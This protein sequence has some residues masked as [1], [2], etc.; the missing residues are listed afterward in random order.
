MQQT[1]YLS[2]EENNVVITTQTD[3]YSLPV[4]VGKLFLHDVPDECEWEQAIILIEDM[5]SSVQK[6]IPPQAELI[7]QDELLRPLAPQ[8]VLYRDHLERVFQYTAGYQSMP[9]NLSNSGEIKGHLLFMREWLHHCGFERAK[10][11]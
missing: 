4:S 6:Y 10:L 7:V 3:R 9:D 11:D 5:I 8:G 2:I 1:V